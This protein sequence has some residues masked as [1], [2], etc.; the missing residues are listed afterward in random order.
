M[1]VKLFTAL[2]CG[3]ALFCDLGCVLNSDDSLCGVE[4]R[5]ESNLGTEPSYESLDFLTN[6]R[7]FHF[8]DISTPQNI[9]TEEHSRAEF[10]IG[11]K[12][13]KFPPGVKATGKAYWG[14]FYEKKVN[15]GPYDTY[16]EDIGLKQAFDGK[17]GWIGLQIIFEFPTQGSLEKDKI[18]FFEHV[19]HCSIYYH[20]KEHI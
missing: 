14:G 9:C 20:Y 1:R 15:L 8:E 10:N 12:D 19:T 13:N 3:I 16:L 7:I 2:I 11:L 17:P 6:N 5:W 18:F 4:K